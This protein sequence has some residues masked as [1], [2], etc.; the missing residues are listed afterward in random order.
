MDG[1]PIYSIIGIDNWPRIIPESN[2][3]WI[4]LY[5]IS[6]WQY[7]SITLFL[8]AILYYLFSKCFQW[9]EGYIQGLQDALGLS[10]LRQRNQF[11]AI[12]LQDSTSNFSGYKLRRLIEESAFCSLIY[13]RTGIFD[14]ALCV[15]IAGDIGMSQHEARSFK[16]AVIHFQ[17][18]FC[19][20]M[21]IIILGKGLARN[22]RHLLNAKLLSL[23]IE[24]TFKRNQN[25][26]SLLYRE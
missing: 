16:Q 5:T 8:F 11:P 12:I 10:K 19:L 9:A 26:F 2:F 23:T 18:C 17:N 4:N 15:R 14:S 22:R 13:I 21:L 3:I 24:L 1:N 6:I 25:Y 20:L 7:I